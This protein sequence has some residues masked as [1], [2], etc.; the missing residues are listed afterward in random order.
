MHILVSDCLLISKVCGDWRWEVKPLHSKSPNWQKMPRPVSVVCYICGREFG[1]KS[2]SIHEPQCLKKWHNENDQL[3]RKMRRPPPKKPEILPDIPIKGSGVNGGNGAKGQY[4]IEQMNEAA[5]QASQANLVPCES[6]GRTFLPDR[7]MVHQKSCKP[8]K[9][10]KPLNASRPST[11]NRPGTV[12]LDNPRILKREMLD[13]RFSSDASRTSSPGPGV[14]PPP[15]TPQPTQRDVIRA[16]G[17]FSQCPSCKRSFLPGRL[18][19]HIKSCGPQLSKPSPPKTPRKTMHTGS[20]TKSQ[21]SSWNNNTP[22][23]SRPT[24][25]RPMSRFRARSSAANTSTDGPTPMP[26]AV[27]PPET[28]KK[29]ITRGMSIVCY[30]CGREFGSRSIGI[31]ESQCMRRWHQENNRL[32]YQERKNPPVRPQSSSMSL[33]R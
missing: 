33:S 19:M 15:Y 11:A 9:P 6:C 13:N 24:S 17:E 28:M 14:P 7:L 8:G 5:W 2:I 12:T 16:P 22:A 20:P 25:A 1:T 27:P 23:S 4:N 29:P 10:L 18:E 21:N 32:P 31:H 30:I 26:P 3:P